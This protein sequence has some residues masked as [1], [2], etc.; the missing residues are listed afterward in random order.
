[1][2]LN[3][4]THEDY[5]WHVPVDRD[6]IPRRKRP[7]EIGHVNGG[8]NMVR[9]DGT[10]DRTSLEQSMSSLESAASD[11]IT[12][13]DQDKFGLVVPHERAIPLAWL[14][15]LQLARSRALLGYMANALGASKENDPAS[16]TLFELQTT[17][18]RVSTFGV[19]GG[20]HLRDDDTVRPKEKWDYVATALLGMRWD[21]MRYPERCLAV[22]DAFAAQY[23]VRADVTGDFER[24]PFMA[25]FGLNTPLW[26]ASGLTIALTP[27]LAL[28]LHPGERRRPVAAASVNMHTIR[29]ARSFVA[30]PADLEPPAVLPGWL[31]WL[32][33][34]RGVRMAMP[35]AL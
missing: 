33:E 25:K 4:F 7:R 6:D 17:L 32:V 28:H 13:I 10:L 26:A 35:K 5:L 16:G 30:F 24:D 8:H 22:S 20:W 21:V 11:A 19:L 15:S 23:G 29:S 27:Q 2:L 18:L 34:A 3:R 14:A 12:E 9:R 1:M 31:D